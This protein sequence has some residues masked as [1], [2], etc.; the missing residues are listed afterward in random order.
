LWP[1]LFRPEGIAAGGASLEPSNGVGV[2]VVPS[3]SFAV[4]VTRPE[5]LGRAAETH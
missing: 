3:A 5:R 1:T 4:P 2:L